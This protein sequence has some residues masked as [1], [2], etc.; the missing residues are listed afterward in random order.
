MLRVNKTQGEESGGLLKAETFGL[1]FWFFHLTEKQT[2]V[3]SVF[4]YVPIF[5]MG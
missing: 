2:R 4:S 3:K 5:K 1:N